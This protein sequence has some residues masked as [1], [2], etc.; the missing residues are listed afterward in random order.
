MSIRGPI[1]TFG[2]GQNYSLIAVA[3]HAAYIKEV[4]TVKQRGRKI[5]SKKMAGYFT[6][7]CHKPLNFRDL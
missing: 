3:K 2:T 4:C 1:K 5:I 7:R 6:I